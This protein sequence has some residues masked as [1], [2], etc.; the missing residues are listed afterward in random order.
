MARQNPAWKSHM[1]TGRNVLEKEDQG[2]YCHCCGDRRRAIGWDV[3]QQTVDL[4]RSKPTSPPLTATISA[5]SSAVRTGRKPASGSLPR[6]LTFQPSLQDRCRLLMSKAVTSFPTAGRLIAAFGCAR[7]RPCR[8]AEDAGAGRARRSH[9][10]AGLT[11]PRRAQ[12]FIRRSTG[13]CCWRVPAENELKGDF[14]AP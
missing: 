5:G 7:L 4:C 14:L 8:L 12:W 3:G 13:T 6:A 11:L 9:S 1:A 10:G 2:I